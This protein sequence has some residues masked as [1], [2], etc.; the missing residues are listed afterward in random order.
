MVFTPPQ[1]VFSKIPAIIRRY[2]ADLPA[3]GRHIEI[4]GSRP[5]R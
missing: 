1:E 2:H 5:S 4:E 3:H